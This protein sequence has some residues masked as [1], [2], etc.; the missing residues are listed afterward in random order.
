MIE[1]EINKFIG[2]LKT[3]IKITY[4]IDDKNQITRYLNENKKILCILNII[5]LINQLK[6]TWIFEVIKV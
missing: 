5:F 1:K 4:L 6:N 2:K 3:E